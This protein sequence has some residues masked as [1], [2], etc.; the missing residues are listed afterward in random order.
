MTDFYE[1]NKS[2]EPDEA[3]RRRSNI[4]RVTEYGFWLGVF[5][6]CIPLLM[7]IFGNT[8]QWQLHQH[9]SEAQDA[10]SSGTAAAGSTADP[11]STGDAAAG[12]DGLVRIRIPSIHV[13]AM[14]V[15]D[16]TKSALAEG[17]GHF[18]TTAMPGQP[19]NCAIAAHRNVWGCWFA[20]LD[21]L[22]PG[23]SVVLESIK[24]HF[25]YTVTGTETVL[26]TDVD[27]LKSHGSKA[28]LTLVTCTLPPTHRIIVHGVLDR[29]T[30]S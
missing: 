24:Q 27:V 6:A 18:P 5:C 23:D 10:L 29:T 11:A 22:K 30:T 9:W 21:Q 14:V 20:N 2:A 12:D 26:P 8:R 4:R 28:E 7:Y 16:V 17:P 19:G 1:P 13:D 3:A 25:Y 15:G